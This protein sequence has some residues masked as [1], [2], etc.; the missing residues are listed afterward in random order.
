MNLN[1]IPVQQLKPL[2]SISCWVFGLTYTQKKGRTPPVV[3]QERKGREDEDQ[4]GK[5]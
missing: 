5:S 4:E 2:L 1:Y 3:I